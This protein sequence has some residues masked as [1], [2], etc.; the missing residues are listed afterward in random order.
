MN[1]NGRWLLKLIEQ[2][3]S[4]SQNELSKLTGLS[5][6]TIAGYIS[7]FMK[8]GQIIGRAYVLPKKNG[9]VSIGG[10]NIDR[11][12]QIE[13]ELHLGTSNP[14]KTYFSTGGVARNIAENIGRMGISNSLI[15]VVGNDHEG[16]WL[17]E[18]TIPYVDIE[19]I[20]TVPNASTGAYSAVLN[21]EGEMVIALADM[22]IYD[23]VDIEFVKRKWGMISSAQ[24]VFLDTN[25]SK[26]VIQ[27]VLSRCKEE[28]I[29]VTVAPVSAPKCE[30]LP[31]NLSGISWLIANKEEVE[32]LVGMK[33]T[34]QA[35]FF[36][37]AEQLTQR[38]VERVVITRGE[39][40]GF[41]YSKEGTSSILLPPRIKVV[42]VTGAGDAL[43]AGVIFGHING[44]NP[45][46]AVGMGLACSCITL[47]SNETVSKEM[48][49]ETLQ[50]AFKMYKE[51]VNDGKVD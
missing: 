5:R 10:A 47:Q 49:K 45:I 30:K 23:E 34:K 3:P 27:Y 48:S 21:K 51:G 17:L 44:L 29:P 25:F 11:K 7:T 8:Q 6:S 24:M 32:A 16:K 43:V 31:R 13:K 39:E 4:I 15:S 50:E 46:D 20:T 37:A 14:A 1:D 9:V 33:M 18:E 40:G 19:H 22:D 36:K 28:M 42:D 35:D 2:N 26:E 41:F 38:G 12:H